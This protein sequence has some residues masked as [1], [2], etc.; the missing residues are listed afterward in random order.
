M[1]GGRGIS[2]LAAIV[3]C[4]MLAV[5]A[6]DAKS[7]F[8]SSEMLHIIIKAPIGALPKV[9]ATP[10]KSVAG[11]LSVVGDRPETL[12]ITLTLRGLTR[13]RPDV[14]A[15]PPLRVTFPDKPPAGSLFEGQ[16]KLKLVTHCQSANVYQQYLLLEYAA[17]RMYNVL[18]PNSFNVRLASIDYVD[19]D[20]KPIT[21]RLGFF[22]EAVDDM[23]KRNDL[24]EF[25]TQ[26]LVPSAKINAHDGAR[27]A[28]FQ[29]MIGNLDWS[30]T[31]APKGDDC[32]HNARLLT[33]KGKT[34]NLVPVP[35]DFDYSGLVDAPYAVPPVAVKLSSVRA[36]YYNGFCRTNAE[37]PAVAAE[38]VARHGKIRAV[39]DDITALDDGK[40]QKAANYIDGF[41]DQLATP[42]KLIKTCS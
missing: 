13:R 22:I 24:R 5:G 42:E 37:V 26:T 23:A 39:L 6:A 8:G 3:A 38:F 1:M 14:C 4:L 30:M 11:T 12:A 16:K 36:R 10:E 29:Y 34:D 40:R 41:F 17:Y 7:L 35:Y 9:A 20:G 31:A 25:E 33:Q 27:F 18:T 2:G 15:F 19:G 28:L 21:T 32:C